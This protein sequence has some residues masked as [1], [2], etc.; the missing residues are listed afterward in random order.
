MLNSFGIK[1]VIFAVELVIGMG[2]FPSRSVELRWLTLLRHKCHAR[3]QE[4][5]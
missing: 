3:A 5:T 1:M 4:R 2:L